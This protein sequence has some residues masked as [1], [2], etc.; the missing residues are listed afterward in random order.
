MAVTNATPQAVYATYVERV[1]AGDLAGATRACTDLVEAGY[2]VA[3]VICR[4]LAPAQAH[5]GWQWERAELS[6]AGEHAATSVTDAA[7]AALA[8]TV[9]ESATSPPLLMV[10]GEGEWHSLPARMGAVLLQ[11]RGWPVRFVGASTP[12]PDLASYV[13][14]LRPLA[15]LISVT[16]AS[17]LPGAAH[18]TAAVHRCGVP[19]LVGGPA[20]GADDGR[21]QAIGA[22]A[23]APDAASAD[24]QLREWYRD[25][26]P[27]LRSPEHTPPGAALRDRLRQRHDAL[28]ETAF[29]DLARRLPDMGLRQ[30]S[31]RPPDPP[32]YDAD[33]LAHT[34]ADL[35]YILD[36]LEAA[37]LVDDDAVLTDVLAWLVRVL[38]HRGVPRHVVPPGIAALA[39]ALDD[40]PAARDRLRRAA[41]HA[42][43]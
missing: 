30:R 37:V 12:A 36:F 8:S 2:S 35:S 26:P 4:I 17:F 33:Q 25:G 7:L 40:L 3:E 19:V 28:V 32:G 41:E 11:T 15:A 10:C 21:T 20:F 39:R 23:W 6:V 31:G 14:L 18:S 27:P 16:V 1:A 24:R 43:A 5:I 34:R 38:E 29:A 9:E 13:A 22:D 42:T